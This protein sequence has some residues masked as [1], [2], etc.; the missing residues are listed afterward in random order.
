MLGLLNESNSEVFQ[1]ITLLLF[2]AFQVRVV[3][4]QLVQVKARNQKGKVK[5][6]Q[7][8]LT[9]DFERSKTLGVTLL[10]VIQILFSIL[11]D[12]HSSFILSKS[13]LVEKFLQTLISNNILLKLLNFCI[14]SEWAGFYR[15][16]HATGSGPSKNR[17]TWIRIYSNGCRRIWPWKINFSQQFVSDEFIQRQ[18]CTFS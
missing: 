11:H 6:H 10:Q 2:R 5:L 7:I 1:T 13:K 14:I 4:N 15:I 17:K 8:S 16:R 12:Q 9:Q 3:Q 18:K